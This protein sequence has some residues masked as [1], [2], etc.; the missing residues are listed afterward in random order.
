MPTEWLKF[1]QNDVDPDPDTLAAGFAKSYSLRRWVPGEHALMA[2][3][4]L[5]REDATG[6]WVLCCPREAE[7]QVYRT[8]A[9]MD[10]CPRLGEL[11]GPVKFIC[12]DPEQPDAKSPG[13]VNRAMHTEYGHPYEVVPDT[14]HLLQV[15]RPDACAEATVRFLAECGIG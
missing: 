2:R 13:L 11:A 12:S 7:S 1:L 6:D 5:R 8:N 10:L 4:I 9:G 3:S 15:E 14:G